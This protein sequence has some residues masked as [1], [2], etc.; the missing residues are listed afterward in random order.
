[1]ALLEMI[2]QQPLRIGKMAS[3]GE[4]GLTRLTSQRRVFNRLDWW[5]PFEWLHSDAFCTLSSGDG[6][7]AATLAVPVSFGDI[8]RLDST[9]SAVA[10]LRWC[11]VADGVS[12]SGTLQPL[13]EHYSTLLPAVGI[14]ELF[15]IVEPTHWLLSYLREAGLGRVDDVITMV[16]RTPLDTLPVSSPPDDL[17]IRKALEAD[18]DVVCVVDA[19]AFEEQWHYPRFVLR[20][21]LGRS[22]YFSVAELDGQ[23]VGYQFSTHYGDE[24]HITRLAV[25]SEW[26]GRGIGAHLLVDVLKRLRRTYGVSTVTLNTQA[27]NQT[28]QHLYGRLGFRVAQPSLRVMYKRYASEATTVAGETGGVPGT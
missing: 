1:M 20:R 2:S 8:N 4:P 27:S 23:V 26:Q 16:W 17:T 10:W 21:A 5:T 13:L 7:G 28:S 11:A 22:T 6:V 12:A 3:F 18:L 15:C 9:Q 19:S 25:R 14:K 24:A